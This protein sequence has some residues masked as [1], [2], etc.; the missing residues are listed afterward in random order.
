ME[1]ETRMAIEPGADIRMLVG[2]IIV[3][4]DVDDL[5]DRNLRFDSVQ[6]SNEFLMPMPLHV[7]TDDRTVEDIESGEQR[8]G[9]VPFVIMRHGS[10]PAVP[11]ANLILLGM[12]RESDDDCVQ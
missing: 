5:A 10:E 12:D 1:D 4:N 8:R 9:T 11:F 7:A 6:K 3:E 2:G